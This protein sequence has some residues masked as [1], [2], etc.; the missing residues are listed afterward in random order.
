MG[1]G[2][3]S[4]YI[5]SRNSNIDD[6][7]RVSP[8]IAFSSGK[9]KFAFETEYTSAKYGENDKDGQVNNGKS[10]SN[11]RLLLAAYLFF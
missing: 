3:Q 11:I 1:D 9:T 7:I 8:R 4:S 10:V 5:F 6:L 2:L